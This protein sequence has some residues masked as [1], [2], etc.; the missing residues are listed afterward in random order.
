MADFKKTKKTQAMLIQLETLG[1]ASRSK[2]LQKKKFCA[3]FLKPT[4][5]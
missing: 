4:N 3:I 5:M 1:I 2:I